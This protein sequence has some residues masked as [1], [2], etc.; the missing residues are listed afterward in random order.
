MPRRPRLPDALKPL[1]VRA[2]LM[3]AL[4]VLAIVAVVLGAS[5]TSADDPSSPA[6]AEPVP[7]GND[8]AQLARNL[9]DWLRDAAR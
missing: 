7:R 5:L 3:L 9:A 4:A 1:S 6:Q 8:P 2:Y